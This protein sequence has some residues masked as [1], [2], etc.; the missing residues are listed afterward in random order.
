MKRTTLHPPLEAPRPEVRT[1]G[2]AGSASEG[3][4]LVGWLEISQHLGVTEA[5]AQ[6]WWRECGVPVT[7]LLG[8][9]VV[10]LKGAL[11][12]WLFRMDRAERRLLGQGVPSA[13]LR[14]IYRERVGLQAPK[15]TKVFRPE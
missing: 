9:S 12:E 8:K 10:T 15:T 7:R 13:S 2:R 11:H 1:R 3:E 5:V 14:R 6:G 4:I